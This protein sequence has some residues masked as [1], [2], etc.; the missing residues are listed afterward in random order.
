MSVTNELRSFVT[1]YEQAIRATRY[2]DL[3]QL[4]PAPYAGLAHGGAGHAYAL[5]RLGQHRRARTWIE[6]SLADR[7]K[8]AFAWERFTPS[9][10]SFL[11]GQAGVRWVGALVATA[12]R[13]ERATAAYARAIRLLDREQIE[14]SEGLAGALSGARLLLAQRP[15]AGLDRIATEIANTLRQRVRDRSSRPWQPEDASR[16]AHGWSGVLHSLLAWDRSRGASPPDWL[17]R[18][19][20]DLARV[21]AAPGDATL[22]GSWCNGAAG[23][24]LLWTEAYRCASDPL[25]LESARAAARR[26]IEA[27]PGDPSLCCGATGV[28][29][30]LLELELVEPGHGWRQRAAESAW[31]AVQMPNVRWPSGLYRGLPGLVCLA[32][33]L[34][35]ERA[36]GFPAIR[37]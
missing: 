21:P 25:F 5:A 16:F 37:A 13:R 14:F 6:A 12:S 28:G 17:I 35:S 26:A 1:T 7:G 24:V 4:Q 11:F 36:L 31:R 27:A 22:A 34:T 23:A 29:F 30:A 33:D 19:L 9:R 3:R 32:H 20:R 2:G 15:H 10:A 18:S 8:H